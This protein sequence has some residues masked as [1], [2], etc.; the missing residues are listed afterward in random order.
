MEKLDSVKKK[1]DFK[2]INFRKLFTKRNCFVALGYIVMFA[3]YMATELGSKIASTSQNVILLHGHPIPFVTLAGVFSSM[4]TVVFICWVVFYRRVGFYTDIFLL[5][6]RIIRLSPGF[7]HFNPQTYPAMFIS[8][9]S[10]LA[11]IIIYNRNKTIG[12][13]ERKYRN[14]ME[15]FTKEVIGAFANCIDGK[16]SYTNG[17]SRRV[18]IYTKFLAQK[19]GE[20]AQTVDQ[21]YN[22]ALLHDIGKIGIPEAILT[23]PG[24]LTDEEFAIMKNHAA[25][26]YDILKDVTLQ[27]DLPSGARYHHERYDGKG[28]P[29]GLKGTDIPWVARIISVADAFDA[30]SSTR[31]YRKKLPLDYIIQEIKNCSGTQFDPKVANAF[32]ELYEEGTFNYMNR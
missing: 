26:G 20:P 32:I 9:V 4:T 16:D 17:H 25:R 24:K 1:N 30:M 5:G 13:K 18:A 6:F 19:L 31:P 10:L 14:D 8:L 3:L 29:D 22:I 23:K 11:V 21:F 12:R 28:Y 7:F 27:K 15:D 2:K